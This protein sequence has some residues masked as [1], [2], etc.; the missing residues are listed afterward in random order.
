[1]YEVSDG[2][3]FTEAGS[4]SSASG[5]FM[6]LLTIFARYTVMQFNLKPI[7]FRQC[8]VFEQL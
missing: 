4:K 7:W 6:K 3:P 8:C 1:M 2:F 5:P